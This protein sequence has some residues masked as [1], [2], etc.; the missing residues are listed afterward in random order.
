MH[1]QK[2]NTWTR[3]STCPRSAVLP[4]T[5]SRHT[6][7]NLSNILGH[8]AAILGPHPMCTKGTSEAVTV[9]PA[10]ATELMPERR[11]T[12]CDQTRVLGIFDLNSAK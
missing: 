9:P 8:E 10:R 6:V 5:N 3:N 1:P 12:S 2:G 7:Y 4:K 11:W